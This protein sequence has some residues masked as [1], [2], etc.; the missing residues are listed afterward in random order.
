M[1]YQ[2][3][4][5][6]QSGS[7]PP[8]L[9]R[10][11][12]SSELVPVAP[13]SGRSETTPRRLQLAL[14]QQVPP[15]EVKNHSLASLVAAPVECLRLGK[16]NVSEGWIGTG[17]LASDGSYNGCFYISCAQGNGQKVRADVVTVP[18]TPP[19]GR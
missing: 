13:G 2:T 7:D 3:G 11:V 4:I 16:R 17:E 10:S 9:F 1:W 12:S 18:K 15:L 6:E 8:L 19:E 5:V 14:Q